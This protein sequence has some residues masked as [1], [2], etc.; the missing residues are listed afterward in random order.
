MIM[1]AYLGIKAAD[2]EGAPPY[3]RVL[4]FNDRGREILKQMK[5]KSKLP[6]ITKSA[7]AKEL[8]DRGR[9]IFETESLGTDLYN[10]CH[11]NEAFRKGGQE[12]SVGPV[13]VL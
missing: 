11:E 9:A 7:S 10:L 13:R 5:E 12:W 2:S 1:C 8:D 6:I 4:G 3:I